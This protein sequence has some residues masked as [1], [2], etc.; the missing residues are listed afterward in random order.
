MEKRHLLRQ[1]DDVSGRARLL[2]GGVV[3]GAYRFCFRL[4]GRVSGSIRGVQ[5]Q[6]LA[7][8]LGPGIQPDVSE[9]LARRRS[10]GCYVNHGPGDE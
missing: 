8:L 1:T 4:R 10:R 9:R 7:G 5:D 2:E 6:D 3:E